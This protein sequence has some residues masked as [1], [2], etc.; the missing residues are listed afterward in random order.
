MTEERP[1]WVEEATRLTRV[2]ASG[3]DEALQRREEIADEHGYEARLREDGTLVLHPADWLDENGVIDLEEFDADDAYEVPLDGGGFE[4]AREKND[5]LLGRFERD[6][7]EEDAF[8]ARAF[9]EFC[10]N[11][12]A[13]AV[14]NTSEDHLREFLEEYYV[15]N[16]W[17]PEEAEDCVEESLRDLL[18]EAGRDDLSEYLYATK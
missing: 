13:T 6:A 5:R 14:E 8:N 1:D 16:V 11:H 18:T 4:E 12:H 17:A 10:E 2:A 15:R 9:V 3:D 7:S